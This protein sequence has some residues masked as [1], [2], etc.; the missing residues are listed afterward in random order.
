MRSRALIGADV[1]F[2]EWVKHLEKTPDGKWKYQKP[3][4]NSA[5]LDRKTAGKEALP[6]S[7]STMNSA[8]ENPLNLLTND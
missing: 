2:D 4:D 6:E 8:E 1:D 3:L 7:D 5:E